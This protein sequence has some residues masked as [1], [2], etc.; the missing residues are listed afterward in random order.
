MVSIKWELDGVARQPPRRRDKECTDLLWQTV[1]AYEVV[2]EQKSI[3]PVIRGRGKAAV[4]AACG[5]QAALVGPS[6]SRCPFL[7]LW[8]RSRTPRATGSA[9]RA[10]RAGCPA[11]RRLALGRGCGR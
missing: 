5:D 8:R 3:G 2:G 10:G 9:L 6:V 4:I 11:A 1:L 7:E